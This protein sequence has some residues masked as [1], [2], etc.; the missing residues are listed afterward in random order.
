M[1]VNHA[2]IPPHWVDASAPV[3]A[4]GQGG[5]APSLVAFPAGQT[6]RLWQMDA[7][8]LAY[9]TI[10]FQHDVIPG[11]SVLLKP[12]VHFTF[13]SAP[14]AGQ[15]L[16]LAI[17][18]VAA[19]VGSAFPASVTTVTGT[20]TTAVADLRKHLI[21]ALDSAPVTV[22]LSRSAAIV[23]RLYAQAVPGSANPLILF[24]DWH[25]LAGPSGTDEEF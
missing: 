11:A 10:Q 1:G 25:Y 7:T 24:T 6:P 13:A 3:F 20:H 18:F 21:L 15:T 17:D 22:P 12:H 8:D 2:G 9:F 19:E 14:T 23:G 16:R 4:T 5:A